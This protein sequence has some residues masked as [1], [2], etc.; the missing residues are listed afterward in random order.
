MTTCNLKPLLPTA[1]LLACVLIFSHVCT[2]Q[3]EDAVVGYRSP[4]TGGYIIMHNDSSGL[5]SKRNY[6][7]LDHGLFIKRVGK[8]SVKL[9]SKVYFLVT[10]PG[11]MCL[12]PVPPADKARSTGNPD[13]GPRSRTCEECVLVRARPSGREANRCDF[14]QLFWIEKTD[15]AKLDPEH[16]LY[17]NSPVIGIVTLPW[18]YR[19]RR[20]ETPPIVDG[21]FSISA[22]FGWRFRVSRKGSMFVAPVIAPGFRTVNYTSANNTTITGDTTEAESVLTFA[23]GLLYEWN[24]KQIGILAGWDTGLGNRSK[25][26]IYDGAP[27]LCFTIGISLFEAKKDAQGPINQ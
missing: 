24:L 13:T 22:A 6:V 1:L 12:D 9:G 8:D 18:V 21:G 3:D 4:V 16:V 14:Q 27:W 17:A 20:G 15:L 10:I 23:G 11:P 7:V 26:Y 2:A 5:P 19:F 25:D